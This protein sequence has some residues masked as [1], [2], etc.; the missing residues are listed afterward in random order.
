[1]FNKF[2]QF[3]SKNSASRFFS[4]ESS[5][6]FRLDCEKQKVEDSLEEIKELKAANKT[7]RDMNAK[8]IGNE[9]SF[10]G[11]ERSK[12]GFAATSPQAFSEA[13]AK[14]LTA[15]HNAAMLETV[16]RTTAQIDSLKSMVVME[17]NDS[18]QPAFSQ[19]YLSHE[20]TEVVTAA[21]CKDLV[22]I[23]D[24][25]YAQISNLH[26]SIDS[27]VSGALFDFMGYLTSRDTQL[28]LSSKDNASPAVDAIKAFAD[29]RGVSLEKP[30][31]N[32]WWTRAGYIKEDDNGPSD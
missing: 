27:V 28:V 17:F 10:E 32:D 7:L 11:L 22:D 1:M 23:I 15:K 13:I 6:R 3:F 31:V 16:M 20:L 26:K 5:L 21:R 14:R 9:Q 18:K 12:A 25:L 19:G 29:L 2:L 30:A 4:V 8:L 24:N